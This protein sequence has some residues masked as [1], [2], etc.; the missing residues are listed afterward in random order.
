MSSVMRTWV[1][2]YAKRLIS[3]AAFETALY[4]FTP[5]VGLSLVGIPS[6]DAPAL[7]I[8]NEINN[9]LYPSIHA[10]VTT[11]MESVGFFGASS[12][13]V[14]R[15]YVDARDAT[16]FTPYDDSVIYGETVTTNDH[17]SQPIDTN[18]PVSSATLVV[19]ENAGP[20]TAEIISQQSNAFT[21]GAEGST[22]PAF[23][24]DSSSPQTHL[25]MA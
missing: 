1:A 23:Q 5:G 6:E 19:G 13:N 7:V 22:N 11:V 24:I 15:G 3:V 10:G 17:F 25:E 2:P 14:Y 4:N 16:H 9:R 12:G 18:G 8:M 21:V 20:G